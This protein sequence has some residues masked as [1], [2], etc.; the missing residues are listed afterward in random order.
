M[1]ER[2]PE[3]FVPKVAGTI[4][5]NHFMGQFKMPHL[6]AGGI[7]TSDTVAQ[8]HKAEVIM[9]LDRLKGL[10][11]NQTNESNINLSGEFVQRGE[12]LALVL[13]RFSRRR[14]RTF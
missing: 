8:L 11:G 9:P 6:Q 7:T 10:I 14:G 2:G 1:G 13:D 3:L 4:I 12:D 5:P